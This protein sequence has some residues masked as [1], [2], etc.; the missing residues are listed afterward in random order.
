[1]I[2]VPRPLLRL[3]G[4]GAQTDSRGATCCLSQLIDRGAQAD[5]LGAATLSQQDKN[6]SADV[7]RSRV[8]ITGCT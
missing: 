7:Q 2:V 1:L 3:L 6:K 8:N 5:D 4:R